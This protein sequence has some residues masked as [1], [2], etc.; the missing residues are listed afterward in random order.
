MHVLSNERSRWKDLTASFC[1][2]M[3]KVDQVSITNDFWLFFKCIILLDTYITY[4]T[5]V[6]HFKP[7]FDTAEI[8]NLDSIKRNNTV[9]C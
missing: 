9:G 8:M 1:A 6:S 2:E 4:N 7:I 5:T 3:E